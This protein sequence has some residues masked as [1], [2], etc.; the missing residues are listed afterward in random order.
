MA[1]TLQAIKRNVHIVVIL[2]PILSFIPPFLILYS[3]HAWTFEQ[4]YR[5]RTFL[6]FF[7]WLAVLETILNWENLQKN[8]VNKLRS[9]RA[10]LF[11]MAFLLPTIYVTVANYYGLNIIISDLTSRYISP[12]G[13]SE[14]QK[15][16][17]ASWMPVSFEFLVFAVFFGLIIALLYGINILADF[18]AS[19]LFSGI[20]GLLFAIEELYPGGKVTPLQVFVPT[21]ATF[22][23]KILS[24]MGYATRMSF[25][26]DP[27]YGVMP[28]LTIWDPKN[29]LERPVTFGIA[30][31]CAGV[32]SLLIY[33]LT[34]LLFLRKTGIS[35]KHKVVFF[36]IG[37]LV[38]YF[39]NV[40]R[41][42]TLFVI[43]FKNGGDSSEFQMFHGYYGMLFSMIWIVSYPL[44]IIGSQ[45]LWGRIRDQRDDIKKTSNFSTRNSVSE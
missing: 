11:V 15:L 29:P 23:E 44:L 28:S 16:I 20:V 33:S 25:G 18:S 42:V 40:F 17:A 38:T 30:W 6:L 21:T 27:N 9:I 5:G 32:E 10:V 45:V 35:W 37:A 3:L 22:A 34:I 7:L 36:A 13:I 26:A 31:T 19:I 12:L 4:A 43:G 1:N 14:T 2:L 24:F 39:I 8:K 41:V